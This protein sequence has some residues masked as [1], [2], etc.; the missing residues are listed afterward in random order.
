MSSRS[1]TVTIWSMCSARLRLRA[2]DAVAHLAAELDLPAGLERDRRLVPAQRDDASVLHHLLPA[3]ALGQAAQ[4]RLDAARRRR[5]ARLARRAPHRDLLVLG[6]DAPVLA[7]LGGGREVLDQLVALLDL[8]AGLVSGTY[9]DMAELKATVSR[10]E[11]PRQAGGTR[12]KPQSLARSTHG[13]R[14]VGRGGARSAGQCA[15]TGS[16]LALGGCEGG[17][18]HFVCKRV[19]RCQQTGSF[20]ASYCSGRG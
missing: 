14:P 12:H 20:K 17:A 10:A 18:P 19:S 13:D 7:R 11:P 15:P 16:L 5:T 2:V 3:V 8:T 6:A 1:P 4:Q 9:W